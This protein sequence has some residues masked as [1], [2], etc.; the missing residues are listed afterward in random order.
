MLNLDLSQKQLSIVKPIGLDHGDFA[1][2]L[3]GIL[4]KGWD[5]LNRAAE[6][7]YCE[8]MKVDIIVDSVVSQSMGVI[9]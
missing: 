9:G 3:A 7:P 4:S 1:R 5:L 6:R 2:L 8:R